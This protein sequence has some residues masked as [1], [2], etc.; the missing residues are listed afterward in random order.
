ERGIESL[1][2]QAP[3]IPITARATLHRANFRELPR[4]IEHAKTLGLDG[5]SFL[6]A[7]VSSTAFGRDRLPDRSAVELN[8]EAT[9][10]REARTERTVAV[11]R[12]EYESGLVPESP[13]K[14]RRLPQYSAALD[15]RRPFPPVVCNAP[16]TSLVVEANGAVRPGFFHE[17]I[18]NVREHA[19]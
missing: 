13:A 4:L 2:R 15:G 10:E 9:R 1:R 11:Y 12:A 6:A 5:I 14:L 18:G 19:L 3:R 17:P 8:E 7:D 16:G